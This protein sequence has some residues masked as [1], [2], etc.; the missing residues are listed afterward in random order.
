MIYVAHAIERHSTNQWAHL[1]SHWKEVEVVSYADIPEGVSIVL[2]AP[3]VG[4]AVSGNENLKEFEHPADVCY[5]F[6]PDHTH[7]QM[8]MLSR[9]PDH[10]VFIPLDGYRE[11]YGWVAAAIVL[12]DRSLKRG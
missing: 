4:H 5:V 10:K 12:Y 3:D 11:M 1:V 8:D 6:G 7:F 2:L 9:E